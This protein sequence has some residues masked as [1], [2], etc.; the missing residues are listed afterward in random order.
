MMSGGLSSAPSWG[1]TGGAT[2]T[3]AQLSKK[4]TRSLERLRSTMELNVSAASNAVSLLDEDGTTI[5]ETLDTHKQ[6]LKSA[7]ASTSSRLS[8]LQHAEW[9][10][11][12]AVF[13]SLLFF[14]ST[15][16]YIIAKRTRFLALVLFSL[17]GLYN[18][19]RLVQEVCVGAKIDGRCI[20]VWRGAG[21]RAVLVAEV[22]DFIEPSTTEHL[23]RKQENE[24]TEARV[25]RRGAGDAADLLVGKQAASTATR[26]RGDMARARARAVQD[27]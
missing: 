20:D 24:K 11:K 26:I 22:V 3:E 4:I 15:V 13:G 1:R 16:A 12:V 5:R 23:E 25:I 27:L 21:E 2:T 7:L 17:Q 10:E 19:Q 8:R 18:G 6:E 14:T 9:R